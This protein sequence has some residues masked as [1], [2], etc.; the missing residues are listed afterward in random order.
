MS[1]YP[2]MSYCM[3]ENTARALDQV[4]SAF[5][6]AG[7]D[8]REMDLNQYERAHV[9][10]LASLCQEFLTAHETYDP[11]DLDNGDTDDEDEE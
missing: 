11:N 8:W 4:V 6:D 10:R 5:V 9:D 1:N 2:N 7:G 3:I